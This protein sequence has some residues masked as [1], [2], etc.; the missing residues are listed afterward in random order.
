MDETFDAIIRLANHALGRDLLVYDKALLEKSLDRRMATTGIKTARD[1]GVYL[2]ETPAEA[3]KFVDSLHIAFSEFFRNP[4]TFALIEQLVLPDFV[5]ATNGAERAEIRVWSAG[6]A[7]GQEAYSL[8]MLFDD[9][10]S[11]WRPPVAYRIFATASIEH[12]LP[13]P[14]N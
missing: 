5:R 14:V 11:E 8:A 1:Y 10:V 4:L 3:E 12:S 7:A 2:A 9:M 13:R 6:C